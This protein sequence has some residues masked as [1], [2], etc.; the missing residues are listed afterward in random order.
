MSWL[1]LGSFSCALAPVL[2]FGS[3]SR[4]V[5]WLDPDWQQSAR[6]R[7]QWLVE[8]DL[9]LHPTPVWPWPLTLLLGFVYLAHY[10]LCVVA[11]L[12]FLGLG[13]I[14]AAVRFALRFA[15]ANSV[16]FA[17]QVLL[18]VSPPWRFRP[19]Y[20]TRSRFCAEAGLARFDAAL[21]QPVCATLYRKSHWFDGAFPSG[22][23]LWPSL[24]ALHSLDLWGLGPA[25]AYP[26]LH[27]FLVATAAL[28]FC[29]HF[30]LDCLAGT[31]VASLA[32][33]AC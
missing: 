26:L 22:H 33:L 8:H 32:V 31:A 29:H 4:L 3:T 30:A 13:G 1:L 18:P 11:F 17:L 2:G 20:E 21:R 7:G 16:Y 10:A 27:L 14:P 12:L 28:H 5:A 6:T 25:T 15:L 19:E 23:V 9:Q 24:V